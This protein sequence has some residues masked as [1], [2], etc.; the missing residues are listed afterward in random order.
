MSERPP[1]SQPAPPLVASLRVEKPGK[2]K[3]APVVGG[4]R[5]R[6]AVGSQTPSGAADVFLHV[7]DEHAPP[8][9][10]TPSGPI[11]RAADKRPQA[12][13][14]STAPTGKRSAAS[15]DAVG[16]RRER[17]ASVSQDPVAVAGATTAPTHTAASIAS[18][19]FTAGERSR[20]TMAHFL[21]D[22]GAGIPMSSGGGAGAG[23]SLLGSS[24]RS[25][26]S[27]TDRS[28]VA[29]RSV[30]TAVIP[31]VRVINGEIVVDEEM[32]VSADGGSGPAFPMAVV[33]ESGKHLTSHAFVKST[34]NNRWSRE[35]TERFFEALSMCGT[36]FAMISALFP[37]RTREQIKGKYKIEEK[38]NPARVA[39]HLR[40]R[41]PLDTAWLASAQQQQDEERAD[42]KRPGRPR[43]EGRGLESLL[44]SPAKPIAAAPRSSPTKPLIA[45]AV[46]AKADI[47]APTPASPRKS[48]RL[49]TPPP[50]NKE[51]P[52]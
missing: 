29:L 6:N 46:P 24:G 35:D 38:T 17:R 27:T 37:R 7:P 33:N 40:T 32:A 41:K 42:A 19:N 23:S 21:R 43:Q 47:F 48:A 10:E 50:K 20:V 31:Q 34:G 9:D 5:R 14:H 8:A 18:I 15:I 44:P 2:S 51:K 52:R 3:F 22:T 28:A 49:A 4:G 13:E 11:A 39:M 1:H 16:A 45:G 25:T 30:A 36:D 12:V 26:P